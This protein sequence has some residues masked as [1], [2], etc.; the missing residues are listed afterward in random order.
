MY[1]FIFGYQLLI[2]TCEVFDLHCGMQDFYFI[3]CGI[4]DLVL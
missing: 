2:A 4:W 3:S 1:L